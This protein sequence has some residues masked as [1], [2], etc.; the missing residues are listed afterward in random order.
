MCGLKG[1]SYLIS[2]QRW[3]LGGDWYLNLFSDEGS[4]RVVGES[5]TSYTNAVLA[6]SDRSIGCRASPTVSPE[7]SHG[8]E[9]TKESEAEETQQADGRVSRLLR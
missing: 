3:R 1:P 4:A 2:K 8:E 9:G 6:K 7:D 5:S